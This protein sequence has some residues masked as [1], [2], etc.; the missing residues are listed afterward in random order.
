MSTNIS[1][2]DFYIDDN[3]N[4]S[5]DFNSMDLIQLKKFILD[6]TN[7]NDHRLLA[8]KY[9]IHNYGDNDI[10]EL[11]KTICSFYIFSGSN[12]CSSF[13]YN[14]CI[15]EDFLSNDL[16]LIISEDLCTRGEEIGY[17]CTDYIL[18]NIKEKISDTLYI[19]CITTLLENKNY[20]ENCI[21]YTKYI[22]DKKN[23]DILFKYKFILSCE[24]YI[25]TDINLDELN[26]TLNKNYRIYLPNIL[27][28]FINIV[29]ELKN[30]KFMI[31]SSQFAF[32]L[33]KKYELF[34]LDELLYIQ[35]NIVHNIVLNKTIEYNTRADASDLILKYGL[36]DNVIN[37]SKNVINELGNINGIS[38]SIYDNAQNAHYEEFEKSVTEG[39]EF[40]YIIPD[41]DNINFDDIK[42]NI[43]EYLIMNNFTEENI[44]SIKSSLNRI[45]LDSSLYSKYNSKLSVILKKIWLYIQYKEEV[46]DELLNRL[47]QELI[48]MCD[49]CSTGFVT[50]LI[51]TMSGFG[52]FS[53]KIKWKD[54][55]ISN[56]IGRLNA[57]IR[58]I[59]NTWKDKIDSIIDKKLLNDTIRKKIIIISTEKLY[60]ESDKHLELLEKLNFLKINN[61]SES[62]KDIVIEKLSKI[63]SCTNEYK[64]KIFKDLYIEENNIKEEEF[65]ECILLDFQSDI[66]NEISN[67]N[68]NKNLFDLFISIELHDIKNDIYTEFE[69]YLSNNELEEYF[70]CALC[71]Y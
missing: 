26:S 23:I 59:P 46:K 33:N 21:N 42:N 60:P 69:N 66:L 24:K 65:D 16:K 49:I 20:V 37:I 48:D 12:I 55:I 56:Y 13:L 57:K 45:E 64:R 47:I 52:D 14:L 61:F 53:F 31:L 58:N 22:F 44:N 67:D 4:N 3:S 54:Q 41:N 32:V 62:E 10:I 30:Y 6:M 39:I 19:K 5:I 9:L 71:K 11:I 36:S 51:N 63:N 29:S 28:Y 8:I 7:D 50:R 27:F 70:R 2:I 15:N 1:E 40:L 68:V 34:N 38:K 25:S 43:Y 17:K 35:N 18:S